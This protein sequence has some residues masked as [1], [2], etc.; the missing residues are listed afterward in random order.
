MDDRFS[1]RVLRRPGETPEASP[2]MGEIGLN[3]FAPYL[4]NRIA[5]RWNATM[6]E[7]LKV[8]DMTTLKMRTL[9]ILSISSALTVNELALYAVTEQSTMSRTLDA[10]EEQGLVRR[11]TRP[12]DMRVREVSITEQ[13]RAAF[14]QVWPGMYG[15]FLQMFEGIDEEEYRVFIATLHRVLGNLRRQEG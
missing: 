6:A 15:R 12:E 14:E 8:H 2:T 4:M 1:G 5:A 9:A 10:M 7:D 11:Q 13:G 3:Q